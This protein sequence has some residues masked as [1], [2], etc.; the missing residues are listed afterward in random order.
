VVEGEA[1]PAEVPPLGEVVVRIARLGGY[2]G[3]KGDGPPGPKAM[4]LGRQ[5]MADL[6][7]GWRGRAAPGPGGARPP[8]SSQPTP[9]IHPPDFS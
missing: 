6:A 2:L 7:L 3:R 9:P 1:P 5:R 8:P 4:W